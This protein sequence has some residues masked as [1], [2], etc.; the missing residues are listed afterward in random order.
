MR[1][2]TATITVIIVAVAM[3]FLTLAPVVPFSMTVY[4]GLQA[5]PPLLLRCVNAPNYLVGN[6][7]IV[8]Q[9]YE[10]VTDYLVGVGTMVDTGCTL[11]NYSG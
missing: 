1:R 8:Y 10:S 7:T 6:A 3:A 5:E 2:R 11:I 9:G 4:T